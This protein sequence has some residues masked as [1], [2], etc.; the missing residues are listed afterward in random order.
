MAD[1]RIRAAQSPFGTS[2]RGTP[3]CWLLNADG[4]PESCEGESADRGNHKSS[5]ISCASGSRC[6]RPADHPSSSRS[7]GIGM[8]GR[9]VAAVRW[10]CVLARKRSDFLLWRCGWNISLWAPRSVRIRPRPA[11][12]CL[13]SSLG[14]Y[15]R[16]LARVGQDFVRLALRG[17]AAAVVLSH[18]HNL[19]AALHEHPGKCSLAFTDGQGLFRVVPVKRDRRVY[20]FLVVVAVVFIFVEREIAIRPAIDA[21]FDGIFGLFGRPLII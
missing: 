5:Q 15:T 11:A 19:Q 12:F 7:N 6:P 3:G 2:T 18:K 8:C 21:Q 13:R 9:I 14:S 4:S 17:Y 16:P 1:K 10:R 20:S